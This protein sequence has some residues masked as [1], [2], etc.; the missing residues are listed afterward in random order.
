MASDNGVFGAEAAVGAEI[1][2]HDPVRWRC[3]WK[4]EKYDG[5]WTQDQIDAGLAGLPF[6]VLEREGNLLMTVGAKDLWLGLRGSAIT[7]FSNAN[8]RLGV[9]DST[10]AAAAAQTDL[11]AASNKTRVAMNATYP[12]VG[13]A[14]GLASDNQIQFQATFGSGVAEWGTGWQEWAIFNAASTGDMLNRK[15][16]NLGVKG[17]STTWTLT[18]TLSLS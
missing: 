14:D 3:D 10:T 18:V 5:D 17:A 2:R 13:T 12:K 4:V 9:G 11:Q 7:A 6:E 8:A 15:V 16:E 1:G